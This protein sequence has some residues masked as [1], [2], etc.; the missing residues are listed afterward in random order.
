MLSM[1]QFGYNALLQVQQQ[2]I[3][4]GTVVASHPH[5]ICT[6]ALLT[7]KHGD[8]PL[9]L[10]ASSYLA[11]D[12]AGRPRAVLRW[13]ELAPATRIPRRSVVKHLVLSMHSC[14]QC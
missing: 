2:E 10:L 7:H 8:C 6:G 3:S 9:E 5:S 13:Q 14:L 4:T 12:K 1:A 11:I